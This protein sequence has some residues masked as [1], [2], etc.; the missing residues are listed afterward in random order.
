MLDPVSFYREAIKVGVQWSLQC[1][2]KNPAEER[3]TL[4]L[5]WGLEEELLIGSKSLRLYRIANEDSVMI[6]SQK[7]SRPAKFALFSPDAN[8][9]ASTGLYDR[10]IKLWRRQSVEVDDTKFDFTYLSHPSAVTALHWR[11]SKNH[12][13]SL[14]NVLYSVGADK[15]I[16]VWATSDP[17]GLEVLQLWAE[18][19]MLESIQ[20]RQ[21]QPLSNERYAFFID[22]DD[23]IAAIKGTEQ[24]AARER[25]EENHGLE[26]LNEMVKRI[27]EVCVVLDGNGNMSAWGLED[28]SCKA[29]LPPIVFNIAHVENLNFWICSDAKA[30]EKYLQILHFSSPEKQSI[31]TLLVHHFDGRIEWLEGNVDEIFDPSARQR[32]LRRKSVWT[33]HDGA[34]KKIVR[35]GSGKTLISRTND[36]E[37][38]IWKQERCQGGTI[39]TRA[40]LLSCSDHIHRTCLIGGGDFVVSL[41]HRSVS[42]WDV[43]HAV[44]TQVASIGFEL[45]GDLLCLLLL[46]EP[47]EESCS[48]HLATITSCMKGIAWEI[49]LGRSTVENGCMKNHIYPNISLFCRFDLGLQEDVVFF[50]PVDPAG[51]PLTT[52]SFLDTFAKDIAISYTSNGILRAWTAVIDL[53]SSS[54]RWLATSTVDTGVDN[55]SL[56]SGSSIRKIALVD[57]SRTGMTIWDI[58]SAQLEYDI[59]YEAQDLVQD[60]DWSSTPDDQSILAVGFPHKVVIL[61]QMRYDYIN[62]G[63]AWAPIREIHLKESTPHPIGDSTWLGSGNLVVGSGNQ[64]YVYDKEVTTADE[65]I[66]DL[67]TPVHSQKSITIFDLVSYLNGP[68]P[69]FHPQFLGQCILAGKLDQ[70]RKVIINLHEALKFFTRGEEPNSFLNL[71][72]EEFYAGNLVCICVLSI[73][74]AADDNSHS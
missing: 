64:L 68:L 21:I 66:I 11:T 72:L 35:S 43:R 8:L 51:S 15:K 47:S 55:P 50:L 2:L 70:V 23:F 61:S 46:R 36:N 53:E 57:S 45:D 37:G 7:L 58:S 38:L 34:V 41:H 39:L 52:S 27:P 6:W 14:D 29:N 25:R 60:L 1:Y 33:G 32:R 16:R 62:G 71:A 73:P 5:S 40:S 69:V 63:P 20:P 65:L 13:R 9:V 54:I 74:S 18:I 26:H 17:H 22:S 67:S 31:I 3:G 59:H 42:L 30:D 12:E 4:T 28:V 19:D 44:A 24:A 56:A 10:L 49:Q 48:I